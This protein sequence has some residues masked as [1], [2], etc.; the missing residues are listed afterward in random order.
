MAKLWVNVQEMT[1]LCVCLHPHSC[2]RPPASCNS[3]QLTTSLPKSTW[4]PRGLPSFLSSAVMR[5]F[6][7][8]LLLLLLRPAELRRGPR[9]GAANGRIRGRGRA[10]V[11]RR[12]TQECKEYMEA[13]EKYLDC[14]DRQLTTVMHH[15]PKDIHH[16]LL[17]RNKIQVRLSNL[18]K[19][20]GRILM[21]RNRCRKYVKCSFW[22]QMRKFSVSYCFTRILNSGSLMRWASVRHS[23]QTGIKDTFF[24]CKYVS[25]CGSFWIWA[26]RMCV[27]VGVCHRCWE[28]QNKMVC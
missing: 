13:G 17:A 2:D 12:Q 14:Q 21:I 3:T 22:W 6:A 11:T 9:S 10:G 26:Q 27:C 8:L 23:F 18:P 15:W 20:W 28:E 19:Q 7:A 5:I 4:L 1:P 25:T 16:L 24:C